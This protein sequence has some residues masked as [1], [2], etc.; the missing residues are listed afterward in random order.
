MKAV[1]LE[2][3]CHWRGPGGPGRPPAEST[4][5]GQRDIMPI[6]SRVP[7]VQEPST[8]Q[9]L[10]DGYFVPTPIRYVCGTT[11]SSAP[12]N[13]RRAA[14]ISAQAAARSASVACISSCGISANWSR[15]FCTAP[16]SDA[17][18]RWTGTDS[19]ATSR[20]PAAR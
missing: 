11:N 13:W 9:K 7:N 16:A 10:G 19:T 2:R 3:P 15:T 5:V 20:N 12:S 17:N 14:S 8:Q 6:L 1:S 4:G 18:R